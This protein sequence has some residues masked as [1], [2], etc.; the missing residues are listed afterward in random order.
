MAVVT[1]VVENVEAVIIVGKVGCVVVNE[2]LT[3]SRNIPI[4]KVCKEPDESTSV[5]VCTPLRDDELVAG[6]F[7]MNRDI[8]PYATGFPDDDQMPLPSP[9]VAGG[10]FWRDVPSN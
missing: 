1:V 4:A 5:M 2:L 7:R 10:P 8:A 6:T 9:A 3:W